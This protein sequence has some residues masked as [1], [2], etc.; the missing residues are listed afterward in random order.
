[1]SKF[2]DRSLSQSSRA[3]DFSLSDNMTGWGGRSIAESLDKAITVRLFRHTGWSMISPY[4]YSY[5]LSGGVRIPPKDSQ[6]D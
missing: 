2:L 5:W 3:G 6:P 4:P 1:M